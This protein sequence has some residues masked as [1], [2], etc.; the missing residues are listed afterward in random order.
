MM[1][2]EPTT[3]GTTIRCSTEASKGVYLVAQS[4]TKVTQ[5]HIMSQACPRH[6]IYKAPIPYLNLPVRPFKYRNNLTH[7][8]GYRQPFST[9]IVAFLKILGSNRIPDS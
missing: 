2:L 3:L 5:S 6:L 9:S 7:L 1:G 4:A 8:K